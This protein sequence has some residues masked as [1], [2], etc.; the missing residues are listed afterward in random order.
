MSIVT[1]WNDDREQAGKTLI[2]VALATRMAIERNLK[3]L[4][5][6]TAYKDNTMR[7]CFWNN[8]PQKKT[9]LFSNVGGISVESGIEGL[10]KLIKS[11][12]IQASI[13]TDYTKVIFKDRLE[14]LRGYIGTTDRSDDENLYDYRATSEYYPELI[15]LANEYYDM[16]IVDLDNKL[17]KKI[18][19]EILEISDLNLIVMS[20][21]LASL[22]RYNL[23]KM[24]NK[25]I[26]G[27]KYIPVIGRYDRT[28]KYNQKN[29][30]RY[31]YEKKD[32]NI[33]P[34]NTLFFEAAEE[35][36]VTELFLKLRDI[37]DTSDTNYF[38]MSE[39]LKLTNN[40][41]TRLQEL[42]MKKR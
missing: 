34:Y 26:V 14:V 22:N 5:I 17:D 32:I 28:S 9:G 35:G 38:F 21:R 39:V 7:N 13:I 42:Q 3:I 18:K 11:N 40:V 33:V 4:L 20:Q 27:P 12:K 6:S 30:T 19:K 41:I 29:I 36:N 1:F 15:K 23:M 10:T 8:G 25:E 31:L 16:V 37:K 2:S 24:D